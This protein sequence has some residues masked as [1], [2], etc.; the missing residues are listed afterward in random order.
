MGP[1]VIIFLDVAGDGSSRFIEIS[2]LVDPGLLFFQAAVKA[3]DVAISFGMVEGGSSMV[4]SQGRNYF[5]ESGRS[6]LRDVI[7]GQG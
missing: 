2:V 6:K 3:F 7:C 4:D 5:Y 1:V